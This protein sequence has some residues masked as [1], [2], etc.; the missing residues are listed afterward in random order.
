MRRVIACRSSR[1]MAF[2]LVDGKPHELLLRYGY[3]ACD[4]V[5]GARAY[6]TGQLVV[7]DV[8]EE[9]SSSGKPCPGDPQD[10]HDHRHARPA[11][12]RPPRARLRYGAAGAA[13]AEQEVI[14]RPVYTL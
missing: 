2:D 7:V 11:A 10:G 3:G 1:R 14:A 13:G 4:T 5:H 9:D 12:G 8:D 6:E